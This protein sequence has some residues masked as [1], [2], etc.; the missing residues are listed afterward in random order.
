M[1][2][3]SFNF[4]GGIQVFRGHLETG[5]RQLKKSSLKET[6][7]VCERKTLLTGPSFNPTLTQKILDAL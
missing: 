6:G 1:R 2:Y 5:E 7:D 4:F 3:L